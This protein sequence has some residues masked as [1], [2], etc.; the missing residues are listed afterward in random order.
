[1]EM[2]NQQGNPGEI[3]KLNKIQRLAILLIVVGPESAAH[4]LKNLDEHE[5]E[6]GS[7]EMSKQSFVNPETQRQILEE[8]G[9]VALQASTSARGGVEYTQSTLEKALGT[10]KASHLINRVSPSRAPTGPMQKLLDL[11]SRQILH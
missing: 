9:E 7:A 6:A 2:M 3:A 5:L 8:F 1:I 10:F 11:D 4:I